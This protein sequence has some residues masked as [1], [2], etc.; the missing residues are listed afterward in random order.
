MGAIAP[1]YIAPVILYFY[2]CHKVF[3]PPLYIMYGA[4]ISSNTYETTYLHPIIG[5]QKKA[6]RIITFWQYHK[7]K[8]SIFKGL[9]IMKFLGVIY[10]LNC[11]FMLKFHFTI[12]P[13]AFLNFST[14]VSSRQKYKT[15]LASR[16]REQITVNL[17]FAS[18]DLLFGIRLT[19]LY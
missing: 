15:R 4:T 13:S 6:V 9:D 8:S 14:F 10:Y 2:H 11:V 7:L 12:L 19:N 16:S 18:R 5:L 17:I 1:V 3:R